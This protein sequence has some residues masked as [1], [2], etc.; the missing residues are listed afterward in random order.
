[1]NKRVE[2]AIEIIKERNLKERIKHGGLAFGRAMSYA[3]L[4][5]ASFWIGAEY[6]DYELA[7]DYM[8]GN[9]DITI[10]VSVKNKRLIPEYGTHD[11]GKMANLYANSVYM[12]LN[13]PE[14]KT[15]FNIID[16]LAKDAKHQILDKEKPK[17]TNRCRTTE[18]HYPY[19]PESGLELLTK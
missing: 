7:P 3:S 6:V 2:K 5:L 13:Y 10:S 15:K 18:I 9:G 4:M 19:E 8:A 16:N 14:L 12:N 1:M 11:F 17:K